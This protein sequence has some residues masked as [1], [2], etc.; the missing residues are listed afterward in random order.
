METARCDFQ[1]R[2][3]ERNAPWSEDNVSVIGGHLMHPVQPPTIHSSRLFQR[4]S[5]I[6]PCRDLDDMVQAV[7]HDCVVTR[8]LIAEP[9]LAIFITPPTPHF[10]VR[11]N[12]A[13]MT[14]T[15][16][17]RN[18]MQRTELR[19]VWSQRRSPR[20]YSRACDEY[21]S[22]K[23][24]STY[25]AG[26]STGSHDHSC[27]WTSVL[28]KQHTRSCVLVLRGHVFEFSALHRLFQARPD[29]RCIAAD[30]T[31]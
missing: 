5:V 3:R 23:K 16:S 11:G 19:D 30:S 27:V 14:R 6:P 10:M 25:Q 15:R 21:S 18:S 13:S 2:N 1:S 8:N 24:R 26:P 17:H 29:P 22:P 20:V 9:Q 28:H 12:R 7:D 31:T 4:T